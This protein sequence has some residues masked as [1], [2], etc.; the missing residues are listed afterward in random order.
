MNIREDRSPYFV[1][2]T[3][4]SVD[5]VL[6]ACELLIPRLDQEVFTHLKLPADLGAEILMRVPHGAELSLMPDRVSIFITP[7][8]TYYRA[9]KDGLHLQ[10]GL[11]YPLIIR[12]QKAI[13]RWYKSEDVDGSYE[14]DAG[15]KGGENTREVLGFNPLKTRADCTT[16]MKLDELLLF[17]VGEYHDF[18]NRSPYYRVILTLRSDDPSLTF[19][20]AARILQQ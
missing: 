20:D 2:Y 13:T 18:H 4:E 6:K 5:D 11:N 9:H 16:S 17:N 10:F 15:K 7:P 3:D 14:I 19:K 1:S 12:D 8:R